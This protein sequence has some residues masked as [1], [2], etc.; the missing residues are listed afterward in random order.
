MSESPPASPHRVQKWDTRRSPA[1]STA[2]FLLLG[3]VLTLW[4]AHSY[5]NLVAHDGQRSGWSEL[6]HTLV[7]ELPVAQSGLIVD[8]W[9]LFK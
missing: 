5:A 4:L 3:Y 9:V 7:H 8:V 2:P 1:R 6:R